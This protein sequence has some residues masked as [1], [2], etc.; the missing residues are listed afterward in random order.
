MD[1]E[2]FTNF[3]KNPGEITIDPNNTLFEEVLK[4][5]PYFQSAHLLAILA[6]HQTNSIFY[7]QTIRKRAIYAADREMLLQL[8]NH[9]YKQTAKQQSKKSSQKDEWHELQRLIESSASTATNEQLLQEIEQNSDSSDYRKSSNEH[10]NEAE[11]QNSVEQSTNEKSS[12]EKREA[13]EKGNEE[14]SGEK[15]GAPSLKTEVKEQEDQREKSFTEWLKALKK[16]AKPGKVKEEEPNESTHNSN[17]DA[18]YEE[19]I[20]EKKHANQ[21]IVNHFLKNEPRLHRPKA[22]FYDP[23]E[24]A[25]KSIT[26]DENLVSET[27]AQIHYEQGHYKKAIDIYQRL[28]LLYPDKFDYFA[29]K[30]NL[31]KSQ[32]HYSK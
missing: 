8:V 5:Y 31:I 22:E 14:K 10:E 29:E 23:N 2:K 25:K 12:I 9:P 7:D 26:E 27:L 15:E 19:D 16:P 32:S 1:R 28:S 13:G 11:D 24:K 18:S 4:A 17:T 30:I 21:E 6:S 20:D 3:I